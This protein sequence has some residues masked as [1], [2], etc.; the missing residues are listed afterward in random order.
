MGTIS[1][2]FPT[3][4]ERTMTLEQKRAEYVTLLAAMLQGHS[5]A[6]LTT[7]KS[8]ENLLNTIT[9]IQTQLE[10]RFGEPKE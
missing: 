9:A 6:G 8:I 7:A 2:E 4:D 10:A 1:I 3:G 5:P